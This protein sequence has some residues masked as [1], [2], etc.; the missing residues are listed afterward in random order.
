MLE[1]LRRR[2]ARER[3]TDYCEFVAPDE[4]PADHH[5]ILCDALDDV[6]D[7]NLRR[8]MVFMPPGSAKSTY[9]TVRFP[10]YYLGKKGKKSI[11]CGSYS[12]DLAE[13]FG[14]KCRNLIDGD[15]HKE[16]FPKCKLSD[17]TK[18]KGEWETSLG[19]GYKSCGVDGSV[20]G[21]RA[22]LGL[23]DDPVKGRKEADSDTVKNTAWEWF[24]SDFLTRLKPEAA[25][26]IIQ[27]RWVED[28]ISG[29]ILPDDWNGESGDFVGFDGQIWKVISIQA[30][31]EKGLNDPLGREPGEYLWTDWFTEDYWEET[32]AAQ[33]AGDM[34][35]WSALYQQRPSPEGGSFFKREW[36][37]FYDKAPQYLNKYITHDDAV[38]EESEGED[39]DMTE[40]G[41]WG[42]DSDDNLYALGWWSGME[43]MNLWIDELLDR[44]E[45]VKP[46]AIVGESGVI[47]RAAEPY[48]VKEMRN[49]KTYTRLEWLPT[50]GDKFARAR[51]FQALASFGKVYFPRTDWADAVIS[52]LV[53]FPGARYD[54]KVDTCGLIGR[55]INQTW[56]AKTPK[57]KKVIPVD[58]RPTIGELMQLDKTQKKPVNRRIR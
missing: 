27:T 2:T 7:G 23:I 55:A 28:D 5:N 11:I 3:F 37:K 15:E 12:G 41:V 22:D 58:A 19:G 10:A 16:L 48:L 35:N 54:D 57:P 1:S 13:S 40:I 33:T 25:V 52:Q 46:F 51:A 4:P 56:S 43:T 6:V 21:R 24:K 32:K 14:K 49:R 8:L 47:R 26:V 29:R 9:S 31:A 44:A 53:R 50:I 45:A 20:T 38:T 18:A 34:R 17:D 39:P 42:V 30:Q 36:F